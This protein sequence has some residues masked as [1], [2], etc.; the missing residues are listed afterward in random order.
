MTGRQIVALRKALKLTQEQLAEKLGTYRETVA[1]WEADRTN[2]HR[3]YLL[4]LEKL[5]A[6]VKKKK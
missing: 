1:R 4:Q 5:K 2:P 6:D 3:L